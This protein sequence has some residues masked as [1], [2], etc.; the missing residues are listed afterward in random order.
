MSRSSATR[1]GSRPSRSSGSGC[2]PASWS[3]VPRRTAGPRARWPRGSVSGSGPE[4]PTSCTSTAGCTT[5]GTI[6]ASV[7][8]SARPGN[9]RTTCEACSPTSPASASRRSGRRARR[10]AKTC[11]TTSGVHGG[12]G[13]ISSN[14]TGCPSS[15]RAGSGA[16]STIS[17]A[18][19]PGCGCRCTLPMACISTAPGTC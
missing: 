3:A 9:T 6:P 8:R 1:S 13:R 4:A 18:G 12:I 16:G 17:I 11:R 10:S 14:T 5:S 7:N 15:S 2:Q 19:F